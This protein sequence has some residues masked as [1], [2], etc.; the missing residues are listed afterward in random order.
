MLKANEI[1]TCFG[2]AFFSLKTF[3]RAGETSVHN[4]REKRSGGKFE[5]SVYGSDSMRFV[6]CSLQA[7]QI[8]NHLEKV[9]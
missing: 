4:E 7:I 2:S 6:F 1:I 8:S 5:I 9:N 3:H